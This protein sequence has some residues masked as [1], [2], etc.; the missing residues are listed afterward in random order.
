MMSI[1]Y[2]VHPPCHNSSNEST[3]NCHVDLLPYKTLTWTIS[4]GHQKL[5]NLYQQYVHKRNMPAKFAEN[6]SINTHYETELEKWTDRRTQRHTGNK[7]N[8]IP[9]QHHVVGFIGV[10]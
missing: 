3:T 6:Q 9:C 5:S 7:Q 10:H 2:T 8:I 1:F 4:Y